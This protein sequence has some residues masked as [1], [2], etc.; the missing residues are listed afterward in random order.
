MLRSLLLVVVAAAFAGMSYAQSNANVTIGV[1]KTAA[2]SGKQMYSSYCAPCHGV[3]GH[4]DGPA[5]VALK[6][7]PTDLTL[8]SR[9]NHGAF[10]DN[11]IDEMLRFGVTLPSHGSAQM[12]IWGPILGKMDPS[13]QLK[14][15]RINNLVSYL[16]SMQEK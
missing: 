14:Q 3:N 15:L 1:S 2:N 11:N 4:G 10:P 12:P 8:L 7:P 6:T 5:A 16:R 9:N 13:P